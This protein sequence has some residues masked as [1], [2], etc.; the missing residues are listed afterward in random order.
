MCPDIVKSREVAVEIFLPAVVAPE[1]YWHVGKRFRRDKFSWYS[2]LHRLAFDAFAAFA[3]F[4]RLVVD[5]D[6]RAQTQ[7]LAAANIHRENWIAGSEGTCKICTSRDIV[8]L[9][10]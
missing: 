2:V 6:G 3:A 10:M 9:G 5:F 7:A 8:E 4:E 1:G